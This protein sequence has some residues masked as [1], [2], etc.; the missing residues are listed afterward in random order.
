MRLG[1]IGKDARRAAARSSHTATRP[2][3]MLLIL[4]VIGFAS[5]S[6]TRHPLHSAGTSCV[7]DPRLPANLSRHSDVQPLCAGYILGSSVLHSQMKR[8]VP[9]TDCADIL[10]TNKTH[11]VIGALICK[12]GPE[13]SQVQIIGYAK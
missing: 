4:L 13:L 9:G 2:F 3:E 6:T 11:R 5:A 8:F 7:L 12:R 10:R 1:A